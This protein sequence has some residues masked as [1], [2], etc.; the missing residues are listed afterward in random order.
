VLAPGA[1][2]AP[3]G[4]DLLAVCETAL[5]TNFRGM[6]GKM[7]TWYVTP[8]DCDAT[9]DENL[10]RVCLTKPIVVRKLATEVTEVMKAIPEFQK[11]PAEAAVAQILSAIY[12]C[13]D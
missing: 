11:Q 13:K 4:G 1:F 12:P 5:K 6:K 3:T 10:P 7:C 2:A 8:C 9:K